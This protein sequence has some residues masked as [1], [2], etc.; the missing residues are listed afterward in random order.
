MI[1]GKQLYDSNIEI[2][3][4]DETATIDYGYD[5]NDY[6]PIPIFHVLATLFLLP[7]WAI[8][9]LIHHLLIIS[10]ISDFK[11]F[12]A[13]SYLSFMNRLYKFIFGIKIA[14]YENDLK[15]DFICIHSS[16]NLEFDYEL[17]GDYEKY[18]SSIELYAD[19]IDKKWWG[20]VYPHF[21]GW[22]FVINFSQI[23]KAGTAE[24]KYL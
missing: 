11:S 22:Y 19:D 23:P 7:I 6:T 5:V 10:F 1:V 12:N 16:H 4:I 21:S 15:K 2:N 8:F 14:F 3:F 9:Y 17:T 18:C 20:E 13:V 24:I